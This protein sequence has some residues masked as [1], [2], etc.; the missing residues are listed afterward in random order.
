[1]EIYR[2]FCA[3][4][5][6]GVKVMFIT[7]AAQFKGLGECNDE[8]STVTLQRGCGRRA[9]HSSLRSFIIRVLN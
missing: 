8:G 5:C 6:V 1:M 4:L 9:K 2:I 7:V 3:S